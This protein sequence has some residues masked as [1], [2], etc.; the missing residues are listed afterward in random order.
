MGALALTVVSINGSSVAPTI[1]GFDIEQ[2]AKPIS[3]NGTY[4]LVTIRTYSK[5]SKISSFIE[6]RYEVQENLSAIVAMSDEL[7]LG[8]VIYYLGTGP[9]YS[10][11]YQRVFPL[12]KI[13]TVF[14]PD[15]SGTQFNFYQNENTLPYFYEVTQTPSQIVA[16]LTPSGGSPCPTSN[17]LIDGGSFATPCNRTL[18]DAGNF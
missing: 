2:I 15:I 18:I 14:N 9:S 5:L 11:S 6:V 1:Y 7:F 16:Q 10:V 3:N 12:A 4:S 13:K 17:T 8:D